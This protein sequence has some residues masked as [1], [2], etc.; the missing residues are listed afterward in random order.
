MSEEVYAKLGLSAKEGQIY[1]ILVSKLVRTKEEIM[2][3]AEGLGPE[4]DGLLESLEEKKFIRA[5]PGKIPQYNALTPAIAISPRLNRQIESTTSHYTREINSL[6][7]KGRAE[8][9]FLIDQVQDGGQQLSKFEKEVISSL[10]GLINLIS[11]K[12]EVEKHKLQE[13]IDENLQTNKNTLKICDVS[14]N[15]T[16]LSAT[17]KT[18]DDLNVKVAEL[19]SNFQKK[20]ENQINRIASE[21]VQD[22]IPNFE[23]WVSQTTTIIDSALPNAQ[24][25][26]EAQLTSAN[27]HVNKVSADIEKM[28]L[29]FS[30][31]LPKFLEEFSAQNTNE[32]N[33]FDRTIK[34]EFNKL[35]AKL[36]EINDEVDKR[37]NKR[38][39][40]GKSGYQ[41]INNMV[42]RTLSEL[43]ASQKKIDTRI[44]EIINNFN[45]SNTSFT[46]N[47]TSNLLKQNQEF[48]LLIE[49]M[50]KDLSDTINQSFNLAFSNLKS[51]S[52]NLQNSSQQ[53]KQFLNEQLNQMVEVLVENNE[54]LF[55]DVN[56][57]L[58][59]FLEQVKM[60]AQ[61]ITNQFVENAWGCLADI[62]NMLA[63]AG[64]SHFDSIDNEL[65][66]ILS[67]VESRIREVTSPLELAITNIVT[68]IQNKAIFT[69]TLIL[70]NFQQT[71]DSIPNQIETNLDQSLDLINSLQEINDLA[72]EMPIEAVED[73]YFLIKSL[74]DLKRTIEA[75]LNRTKSTIQIIVPR[76]SLLP[77][78]AI[79]RI[80]RRRI[81]ILTSIDSPELLESLKG[82]DNI[83]LRNIEEIENV[84]A[85]A[86]DGTEEIIVGS[87]KKD[88]I[89]LIVTTDEHLAGV[90]KEII[91]D[92]WPRGKIV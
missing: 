59:E 61:S 54:K 83:H 46:E 7:E 19:R 8:L 21:R 1:T 92:Y 41:D 52:K 32:F 67:L 66:S 53:Q 89:S 72:R 37:L 25:Q 38:V 80:T 85:V 11:E 49:S 74:E 56:Q 88:K 5:V 4:I 63:T 76:M 77:I 45:T 9:Q 12:F 34:S 70:N 20:L 62:S 42:N 65:S 24:S 33:I 73:T 3:L 40:L 2:L 48:N 78:E 84:Y 22:I 27:E 47:I 58:L 39:S 29:E 23:T 30:R 18:L 87:G 75:M 44:E 16:L 50:Q 36:N 26:K 64:D 71:I 51:A 17:T 55:T 90:L 10:E 82:I 6:W 81:Q 69:Q 79:K 60:E 31:Q 43:D 68:E 28:T 57:T 15:Q 91:Q 35:K 14:F 13:R 86:R